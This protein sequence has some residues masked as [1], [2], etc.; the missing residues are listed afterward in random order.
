[1]NTFEVHESL[2][3][4][5]CE[6][7]CGSNPVY[8]E[9]LKCCTYHPFLPNYLV[10]GVLTKGTSYAQNKIK[11]QIKKLKFI[12]PMGIVAPESYQFK[13]S[14][15]NA[16][17][18]GSDESLLCPYFDKG[19]CSVWEFRS[20][21]CQQFHCRSDYGKKGLKF[22]KIFGESLYD[23]EILCAQWAMLEKGYHLEEVMDSTDSIKIHHF[24]ENSEAKLV[25]SQAEARKLWQH[26]WGRIEAYYKECY[27]VVNSDQKLEH[28]VELLLA[29][30]HSLK[31]L[32]LS[33]SS[34]EV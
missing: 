6:M 32:H 19:L 13:F 15:K 11:E 1:M 23:V 33:L 10:G 21:E 25:Y 29:G 27:Q 30:K 24:T 4:V 31:E 18:Y 17:D 3:C 22:W 5:N 26:Q 2:D 8:K 20:S 9:E 16:D 28:E 14:F 34:N 12:T 7:S